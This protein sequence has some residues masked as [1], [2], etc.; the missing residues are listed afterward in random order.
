[1]TKKTIW[2]GDYLERGAWTVCRFKNIKNKLLNII[3]YLVQAKK[4]NKLI[5]GGLLCEVIFR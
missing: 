4:Q 2:R 1:M 5:T 3:W